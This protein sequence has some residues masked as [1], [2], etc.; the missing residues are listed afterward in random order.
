MAHGRT[1]SKVFVVLLA[2][3]KGI[4][5]GRRGTPKQF[6]LL[7]EKPV[8][9]HCLET[10]LSLPRVNRIFLVHPPA[11]GNKV[12][13]M[14]RKY[15]VTDRVETVPGGKDRQASVESALLR[16]PDQGL[17]VIQN[18][19]SPATSADLIRRCIL[20]ANRNGAA[21]AFI[22]PYHTVFTRRGSKLAGVFSRAVLGYTCDPQAYRV[23]ILKQALRLAR[24]KNWKD[25]PTVDLVRR[26]G[27]QVHLVRSESSNLKI[28]S[29]ADL[30]ALETILRRS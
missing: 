1:G 5:F 3:G 30:K 7:L 21:T 10:Y 8:F 18:S 29:E 23:A 2:A 27:R 22:E 17:V 24:K 14:L 9:V 19:V 28:T 25:K 15:G 11:F 13:G 4:R 16:V 12:R 26:T 20:S 6:R